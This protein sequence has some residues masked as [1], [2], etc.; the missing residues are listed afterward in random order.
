MPLCKDREGRKEK[1]GN[2]TLSPTCCCWTFFVVVSLPADDNI[3]IPLPLF[4]FPT[5]HS[6]SSEIESYSLPQLC[7]N[8][9]CCCGQ[10]DSYTLRG[11]A[12]P[13]LCHLAQWLPNTMF[14]IW[15]RFEI[16]QS[17]YKNN[18]IM[19]PLPSSNTSK[20]HI[21]PMKNTLLTS[22]LDIPHPIRTPWENSHRAPFIESTSSCIPFTAISSEQYIIR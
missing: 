22:H 12:T 19:S 5:L 11:V 2:S 14:K 7:A 9:L 1:A 4:P 20:N 15:K 10:L 13:L 21:N 6:Y 3:P 18:C 16:I 17:W 8:P